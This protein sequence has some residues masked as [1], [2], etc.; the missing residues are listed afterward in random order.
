MGHLKFDLN[1]AKAVKNTHMKT[2]AQHTCTYKVYK[3]KNYMYKF[4]YLHPHS[5]N[6]KNSCFALIYVKH[7]IYHWKKKRFK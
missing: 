1:G 5:M 3:T 4:P 6:N 2:K 7:F